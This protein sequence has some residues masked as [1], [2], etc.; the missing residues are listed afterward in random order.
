MVNVR[1]DGKYAD[2]NI[3]RIYVL[4]IWC[5]QKETN[6]RLIRAVCSSSVSDPWA[7]KTSRN[8][9]LIL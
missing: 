5:E 4:C 1:N 3:I 7:D 8:C 9:T 2:T 6:R